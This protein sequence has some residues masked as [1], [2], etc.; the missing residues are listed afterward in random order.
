M[1][2]HFEKGDMGWPVKIVVPEIEDIFRNQG[3]DAARTKLLE[4]L[5]D[6]YDANT[7][8]E[9]IK[10]R[11]WFGRC[12]WESDNNVCDDQTVTITWDDDPLS[13]Q[14]AT[15][16]GDRGHLNTR[17]AKSALFHMI[18]PTHKICERRG[19]IYGTRGEISYDSYSIE[20]HDFSTGQIT[21][22][23]PTRAGGGHGGGD[24]GLA[25]NFLEAVRA[26]KVEGMGA[27]EAQR[28]YLG[29]SLEEVVRSHVA[30]FAAERARVEGKQVEWA[31]FWQEEVENRVVEG[32]A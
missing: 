14:D 17:G 22:H 1:T 30:V 12:V 20:V 5:A 25:M 19:R 31:R 18:A 10:K 21:T 16:E 28:R 7:P 6:D 13:P 8:D 9:E 3:K 26:V 27:V 4:K 24:D 23:K 11:N 32:K 2:K 15:S 29:C